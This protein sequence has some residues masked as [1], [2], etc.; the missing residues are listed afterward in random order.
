M[1]TDD[2]LQQVVVLLFFN[3]Q[4]HARAAGC[5]QFGTGATPREA[6][7]AALGLRDGPNADLF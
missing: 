2:L 6:M 1:T 5:N 4:W 7:L 3:N